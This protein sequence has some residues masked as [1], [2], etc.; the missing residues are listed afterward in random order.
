MAYWEKGLSLKFVISPGNE[1]N[2]Q[3]LAD[4]MKSLPK[5]K[6]RLEKNGGLF[7]VTQEKLIL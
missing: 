3:V 5:T 4:I 6:R 2:R 1:K 7:I